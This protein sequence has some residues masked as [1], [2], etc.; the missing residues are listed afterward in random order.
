MALRSH[1]IRTS[2]AG[3]LPRSQRLIELNGL[4]ARGELAHDG[5]YDLGLAEA[6]VDVVCAPARDR[7]RSRQRR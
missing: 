2:H 4:R 7:H 3:S 1:R 6:V 5:A